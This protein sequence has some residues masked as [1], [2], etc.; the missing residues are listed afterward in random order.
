LLKTNRKLSGVQAIDQLTGKQYE[1]NTKSIINA[2]G[3]F[4]DAIQQ[5]DDSSKPASISPSQ[6]IHIVLNKEFLPGDTAIMIPHTDD[7]RVLFA[8]PWHHK[9]I[10]GT[11]DTPVN[12]IEEEPRA[13]QDELD[14]VISHAARYLTKDPTMADIKSIFTGLRPLVKSTAKK[15]AEISRDHTITVSDS[16]LINILGGKWTTYRKMAEDVINV[17]GVQGA[18][19]HR[20]AITSTL[21]IHGHHENKVD[22]NARRYYYG[23]DENSINTLMESDAALSATIHP[24]LPY[25]FAEVAWSVKEEMAIT[26][27]DVLSRRTRA[28]LLDAKAALE[29]APAVAQLMAKQLKKDNTWIQEQINTFKLIANSYLPPVVNQHKQ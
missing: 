3:V 7:G 13:L 14:F 8:V 27:E 17:A 16:G 6:G 12:T 26:V 25:T 20:E 15:T 10:I 22:F 28:L 21:R 24:Q 23:C 5:L 29:A 11:T 18:L 4:S 19:P 1:L 9:I 2:T